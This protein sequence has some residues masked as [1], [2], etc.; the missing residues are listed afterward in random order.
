MATLR[1]IAKVVGVDISTVSRVLNND[2]K[3]TVK[4]ETRRKILQTAR[5]LNYRPNASARTL[6]TG[7]NQ[8]IGLILPDISNPLYMEIFLGVEEVLLQQNYF[9]LTVN[10]NEQICERKDYLNL[11]SEGRVDGVIFAA[12]YIEEDITEELSRSNLEYVAVNRHSRDLENYVIVDD[13][14]AAYRAVEHLLELGHRNVAH[15]SGPLYTTT[16]LERLQGYRTALQYANVP[17][18][19]ALVYET[20]FTEDSGYEGMK[21]ILAAHQDCTAVFATN[22]R[23]AIGA[24]IAMKETGLKIPEDLSIICVHDHPLAFLMNP[25]LTTVKLPLRE[26]GREAAAILLKLIRKEEEKVY[27]KLIPGFELML[28]G[29]TAPPK[30][31]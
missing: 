5:A 2:R 22:F 1:D 7:S 12:S 3:T 25:P 24:M 6:K 26:M 30:N 31:K 15:L 11:L 23:V 13:K 16:A 17:F 20:D 19:N 9:V 29:S 4:D 10:T 28:R 27:K 21:R 14:N 8:M 18:N